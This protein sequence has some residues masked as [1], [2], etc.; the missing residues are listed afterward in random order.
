MTTDDKL[1]RGR[2]HGG[3]SILWRKSLSH[4]VKTFKYDDDRVIGIGLKTS[5]YTLLFLCCYLPY[6]CD[7]F[8]DDYCFYLDKIKCIIES[9][10]TPYVYI[11]GDFNADIQSQSIFGSE[12][13]EFCDMNNM[14]FIDKSMLSPDTFTFISQAHG[15]T[16][17]LD[18]CITTTAGESLIAN[19][20]VLNDIACSDHLPLCIDINCDINPLYDNNFSDK[21]STSKWHIATDIDKQNYHKCTGEILNT[22]VLPTEALLCKDTNCESHYL[23]IEHFYDSIVSSIQIAT[24]KCIPCSINGSKFKVIPGWNDYVKESYAISRDALKWWISNNRPRD[25]LIYHNM[26]TSRAQ[27]K[28]ALRI[29]KRNEET[30]RADALARDLYDKDLDEFLS[31]VRQLNRNSSLLS[32]CIDGVT[33]EKNISN[34]WKEHFYNL[35][36]C[37]GNDTDI[38]HKVIGKLENI[39]Y[40]ANMIVTSEDICKLIEKLKCGKASGPDGISAESLR[41]ANDRLHVLL[42]LCFSACFSHSYLPKSLLETTIVPVIK[43]K[44]GSLT[45]CNNYR[46]IAIA[47]ITSK[48]LES[49]ILL[50]CEEY[51][52]T[53]DNQFGFKAGHS[54]EFCIYSLLE[55]IDFYKKRNTTVFVTFLDASK[56]FD[57]V[58]YWLLFTKLIDKNVP[59]FVV[60]LLMFWYTKQVMKVRW[61]NTLSSSFQ[62]GNGVK[63][64][65]ILSPVLFNTYMDKLSMTLNNTAI[66]GQ[67]GGQLLNHLCYADDMCLISISSAGMQELLNV[68]HSYSIEHSLL[69]NG[70][71]S[72]SLCF[73]P[74]SIKFERPCFFLGEKIIPKVTQCKYL[75][76]I[77]SDHNCDA[78]LKRQMRKFYTNANMLIRKFF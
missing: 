58:N 76:V 23:D 21:P 10:D 20:S 34:Y 73:K 11:L 61:G 24:S 9:A 6:E 59:L 68:C 77:I 64:W 28:Y 62:V 65:G 29:A 1:L 44:C 52:F 12:L 56:A 35:L 75:G 55:F 14:S 17:W 39:Q 41:F 49:I 36:N 40:D 45:D 37:N 66:G 57:R 67:I 18:H 25:G 54:T 32:N 60:K 71:R 31:S 70:N 7:M 78:D 15:T 72:Y 27:F 16:S 30:A 50:K 51:F 13:I 42:S 38:K 74:T 63:Q 2:P 3:V 26:R 8:Y 19:V 46:P 48:L 53:S 69:Y 47:T 5:T 33:G 4:I 43:N 22:I